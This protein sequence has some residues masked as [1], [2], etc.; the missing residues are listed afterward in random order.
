MIENWRS[1]A[2][3]IMLLMSIIDLGATY[4]YVY[5]YKKWQPEKP[6]NLIERNPLL[7]FLWNNFGLH[8]GM[9]IGSVIILSLIYIVTKTA[10]PIIVLILFLVLIFVLYNHYNNIGLLFR[11]I[12]KYPTGHLPETVFGKVVGNN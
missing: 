2:I 7:C 6:Y 3:V 9:F 8:L 5:K 11:L 10:H 12:D 4:F 1:W